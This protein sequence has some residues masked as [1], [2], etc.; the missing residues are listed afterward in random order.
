MV[1]GSRRPKPHSV[2]TAKS[3]DILSRG[4]DALFGALDAVG[5][6]HQ[7]EA[8]LGFRPQLQLPQRLEVGV[9]G[10]VARHRHVDELDRPLDLAA[11]AVGELDHVAHVGRLDHVLVV[12]IAVAEMEQQIDVRPA[13]GCRDRSGC[14]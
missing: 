11:D 9:V 2:P 3:V 4:G 8:E 6:V 14:C 7:A 12:G 1:F 5:V 13:R 10:A